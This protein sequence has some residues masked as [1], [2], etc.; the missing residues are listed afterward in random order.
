MAHPHSSDRNP[1]VNQAGEQARLEGPRHDALV[2]VYGTLKRGERNHHWLQG[3]RWVGEV[4]LPGVVLHDLGPFP[5]AVVGEGRACG[6]LFEV[7]AAT[8]AR[9]D[10]LEGYPRLYDRQQL[11]LADGQRAWV[12]LGRPHQVRH[13]PVVEGGQWCPNQS[14]LG[15]RPSEDPTEVQTPWT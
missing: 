1:G 2:F 8:L 7:D 3:A 4:E 6:E 13:A 10:Q 14:E 5:M 9:L 12:Y 15:Q 11:P